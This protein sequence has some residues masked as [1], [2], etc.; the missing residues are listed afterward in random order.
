MYRLL[1]AA[2]LVMF[3]ALSASGGLRR[4]SISLAVSSLIGAPFVGQYGF[5][6]YYI[7]LG[8][9][10]TSLHLLGKCSLS[11]D[12]RRTICSIPPAQ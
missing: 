7:L 8:L 4:W 2:V 3:Q 11:D 5:P 1:L 6:G 10:A 9:M 12:L